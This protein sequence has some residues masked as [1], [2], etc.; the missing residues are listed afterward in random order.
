MVV[1]TEDIVVAERFVLAEHVER[2]IADLD[3]AR[4][5]GRVLNWSTDTCPQ[6]RGVT[7]TISIL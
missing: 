3:R 2:F 1:L 6:G 4:A 7:F 5:A